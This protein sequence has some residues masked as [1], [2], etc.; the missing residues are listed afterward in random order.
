MLS[1]DA[2]CIKN[3]RKITKKSKKNKENPIPDLEQ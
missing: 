3:Q 1:G 2:P